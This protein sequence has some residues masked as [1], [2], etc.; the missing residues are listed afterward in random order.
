M[1]N[2]NIYVNLVK[3]SQPLVILTPFGLTS[4]T[5]YCCLLL[6]GR[7]HSATN[8]VYQEFYHSREEFPTISD[9]SN[10]FYIISVKLNAS[11]PLLIL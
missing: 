11:N 8:V 5:Y 7:Y 4:L 10:F 1:M 3:S 2:R 9:Q 6:I